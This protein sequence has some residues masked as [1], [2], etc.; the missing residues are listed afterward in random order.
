MTPQEEL[1]LPPWEKARRFWIFPWKLCFHIALLVVITLQAFQNNTAF[2]SYSRSIWSGV[3]SI[4]F[5]SDYRNYQTELCSPYQYYIFTQNQTVLNGNALFADYFSMADVSVNRVEVYG[6]SSSG[7]LPPP[8]VRITST[9]GAASTYTV[10]NSSLISSSWPLGSASSIAQ[11]PS[12]L[13]SF[14][15]DLSNME[16]VFHIKSWGNANVLG[17]YS[18]LCYNWRLSMIYD[19]KDSG[20]I[21]VTAKSIVLDR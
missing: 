1:E 5:P 7:S 16:F 12:S 20:Q 3:V 2:S 10:Y 6:S 18:S 8:Y 11:N 14:F 21:L 4:Y 13:R 17:S 15:N 19:L 9:S